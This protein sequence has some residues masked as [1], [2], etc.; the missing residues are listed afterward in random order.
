MVLTPALA[1]RASP[2][3]KMIRARRSI[4]AHAW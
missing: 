1:Q 2:I 3:N 4:L